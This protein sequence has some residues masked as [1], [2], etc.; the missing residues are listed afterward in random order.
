MTMVDY[1]AVLERSAEQVWDV[2]KKF[3]EIHKWHP[4]IVNSEIEGGVPDGLTGC[5]RRLV[6]ADGTVVRERL[7]S[8]DDRGLTL[9]YRFE[10]A[11]LPLDNYVAT[12]RLVALTE[13]SQTLVTWSASFDLQQP[14]TAEQY[15]ALIRSL[16][17]GGHKGLQALLFQ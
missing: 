16:I 8:V 5:V 1:S 10:E 9:S 11:P 15:Q 14:N 17:V 7:L 2:L 3:G 13:C 6:L 4:S 12:V